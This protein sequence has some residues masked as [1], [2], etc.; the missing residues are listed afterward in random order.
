M[1]PGQCGGRASSCL[2]RIWLAVAGSKFIE[3]SLFLPTLNYVLS[4]SMVFGKDIMTWGCLPWYLLFTF[5]WQLLA[6]NGVFER[7]LFP[8]LWA[9]RV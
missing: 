7:C 2:Q 4:H 9:S 5:G 1:L 6:A 3:N 8:L